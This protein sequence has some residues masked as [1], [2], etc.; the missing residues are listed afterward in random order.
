[1]PRSGRLYSNDSTALIVVTCDEKAHADVVEMWE[2]PHSAPPGWTV[3]ILDVEAAIRAACRRWRVREVVCDVY[4]FRHS[5]D[6]LA[7][8]RLPMV[9]YPQRPERMDP[10]TQRMFD[11]V[12]NGLMT[13]SGD[14]RLARHVGNAVLKVD[15]RGKRI[16]KDHRNS[17]RKIDAAVSLLMALDR[18]VAQPQ[19][20][21]VLASFPG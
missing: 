11:M 16:T 8:E 1:M 6:V 15:S 19:T 14:P 5:F 13:H 12:V 21:D 18:A 17:T 7:D 3:P 9:E 2:R 10:A 20:Y 4:L